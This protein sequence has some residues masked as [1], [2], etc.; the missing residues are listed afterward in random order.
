MEDFILETGLKKTN[1]KQYSL[2]VINNFQYYLP[3]LIAYKKC[4]A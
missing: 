3:T 4:V 2:K 1:A